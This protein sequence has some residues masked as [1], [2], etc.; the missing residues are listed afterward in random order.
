MAK[1]NT[2][3]FAKGRN[4]SPAKVS[5]LK[6]LCQRE[7]GESVLVLSLLIGIGSINQQVWFSQ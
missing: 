6:R 5:L 3:A 1:I 2:N 4:F 7:G